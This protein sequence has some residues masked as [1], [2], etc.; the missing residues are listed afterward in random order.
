[1]R[2]QAPEMKAAAGDSRKTIAA[3]TSLSVPRRRNGTSALMPRI[4]AVIDGG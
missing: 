3:E 4:V 2:R 1:M